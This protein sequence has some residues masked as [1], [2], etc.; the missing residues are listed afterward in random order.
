MNSMRPRHVFKLSLRTMFIIVA[1]LA[2]TV[3][4]VVKTWQVERAE[5]EVETLRKLAGYL[6]T[7]DEPY[8]LHAVLL[9]SEK[10]NTWRWR[11]HFPEKRIYRL[12]VSV[13][14]IPL[15]APLSSGAYEDYNNGQFTVPY[16]DAVMTASLRQTESDDWRLSGEIA[17][18][19][20]P[21]DRSA[22]GY[23]AIG[24][25]CSIRDKQMRWM[26]EV[27]AIDELVFGEHAEAVDDA[28]GAIF[29]QHRARAL[30]ENGKYLPT[31]LPSPGIVVWLE[32]VNPS[33]N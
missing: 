22:G 32:V 13:G 9:P 21:N 2:A 16:G 15:D 18:F 29:L 12:H 31:S 6:N 24:F 26:R 10:R 11:V 20:T 30:Q 7:T 14:D 5:R 25:G 28:H 3:A 33:K 23:Q 19:G 27:P 1:L 8:R 4:T 17:A